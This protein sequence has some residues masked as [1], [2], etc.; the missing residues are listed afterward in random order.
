MEAVKTEELVQVLF[1]V[2]FNRANAVDE[3][4]LRKTILYCK[5]TRGG[6]LVSAG[7]GI[8]SESLKLIC[9]YKSN[10]REGRIHCIFDSR[11][12]SLPLEGGE[13]VL[14]SKGKTDP[15]ARS[16]RWTQ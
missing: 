16:I 9:K 10:L 5:G 7:H 14:R 11:C 8:P 13:I 6:G 1:P 12:F 15:D 4:V 3:G 2:F